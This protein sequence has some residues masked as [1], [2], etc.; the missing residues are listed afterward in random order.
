MWSGDHVRLPPH[1]P[2]PDSP[3]PRR[4]RH[5]LREP[6][7]AGMGPPHGAGKPPTAGRRRHGATEFSVTTEQLNPSVA[8][9]MGGW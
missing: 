4:H 9:V 6:Q 7:Q 3:P 2:L 5:R 1:P 8:V